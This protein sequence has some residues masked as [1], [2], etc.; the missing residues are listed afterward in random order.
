M[1]HGALAKVHE[2]TMFT[3]A[4]G[5]N[6]IDLDFKVTDAMVSASGHLYE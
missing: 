1:H 3:L 4:R 6:G 2:V 5:G